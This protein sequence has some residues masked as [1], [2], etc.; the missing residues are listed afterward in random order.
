M[1]QHIDVVR[2]EVA[3]VTAISEEHLE[4][5]KDLETIAREENLILEETAQAGGT[6][7]I[8]L[9]D[10]WIKP[11]M[12]TIKAHGK[13][14]F[15]LGGVAGP[16][17]VAG[18][19]KGNILKIEGIGRQ[20]FSVTCPLPGEHN[21]RNLLGAIAV[22][23]VLGVTVDEIEEGLAGFVSSGGRSQLE[24]LAMGGKVLCDFYNA[25]PASMRAAFQVAKETRNN[26][27]TLWLCLGDMKE[28][29][30]AEESLHRALAEDIASLGGNLKVLLYGERMKWLASELRKVA[31]TIQL[32]EFDQIDPMAEEMLAQ[33]K[34][35]DFALIKGSR[36]MRMEKVW[37]R[38]KASPTN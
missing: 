33:F 14:G 22:A 36:S 29:G 25:N 5:L 28:L 15:T 12:H 16:H 19:L 34:P 18:R 11:L 21:A 24:T 17:T 3:L 37:E 1:I 13:V 9:D 2:P 20:S 26:N 6:S 30:A 4:W 31:P 8:N 23:L 35:E 32:K 27:G 7:V 38:L 10:P